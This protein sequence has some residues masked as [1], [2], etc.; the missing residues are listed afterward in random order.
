MKKGDEMSKSKHI[1]GALAMSFSLIKQM[2][3]LMP[4]P[5]CWQC[6]WQLDSLHSTHEQSPIIRISH[7]SEVD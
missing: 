5:Q 2:I 1:F 4:L 3:L 7:K 6:L